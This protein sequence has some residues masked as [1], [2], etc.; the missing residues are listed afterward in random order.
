MQKPWTVS[1]PL[2]TQRMLATEQGATAFLDTQIPVQAC[3]LP[4]K[5]PLGQEEITSKR[6]LKFNLRNVP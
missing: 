2:Q 6:K 5:L 3:V 4:G 1:V